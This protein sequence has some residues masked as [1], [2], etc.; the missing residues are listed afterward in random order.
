MIVTLIKM[1]YVVLL[2][3]RSVQLDLRPIIHMNANNVNDIWFY[4]NITSLYFESDDL[5][6]S[7][8]SVEAD[9]YQT[10]KLE[11]SGTTLN[12]ATI[13]LWEAGSMIS[14]FDNT[15]EITYLLRSKTLQSNL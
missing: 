5:C 15:I 1:P 8:I 12:A 2:C 6:V 7:N 14:S 9:T 13:V 4:V 10:V 11:S 3:I